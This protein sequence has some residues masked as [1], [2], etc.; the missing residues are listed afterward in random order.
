MP[1]DDAQAARF[2]LF[3]SRY[4]RE[5]RRFL[6]NYL[7]DKSDVDDCV[8]ESFLNLWR[9]EAKGTLRE[10][11]RG[12]LFITARNVIRDFKRKMRVRHSDHHVPLSE[13]LHGLRSVENETALSHR[14]GLRLIE[15]QLEG[16][17]PSTRLVFLLHYVEML[18]F[19][20]IA[21]RLGVTTRTVEREMARALEHCRA[22]L[23]GAS[24]DIL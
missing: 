9:Q 24:K 15:A 7:S 22:A 14:E 20:D 18:P 13:D 4:D 19:D 6:G 1:S 21:K 11:P 8:Q 12:Y 17:R 23:A 5:L 3:F 10:D 2:G 16:L